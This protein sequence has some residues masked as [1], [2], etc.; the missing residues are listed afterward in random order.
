VSPVPDSEQFAT[1][2]EPDD[3]PAALAHRTDRFAIRNRTNTPVVFVDDDPLFSVAEDPEMARDNPMK[4]GVADIRHQNYAIEADDLDESERLIRELVEQF[5][6]DTEQRFHYALAGDDAQIGGNGLDDF[7]DAVRNFRT[8]YSDLSSQMGSVAQHESEFPDRHMRV[9]CVGMTYKEGF[10]LR[11]TVWLAETPDEQFHSHTALSLTS[12]EQHGPLTTMWLQD[13]L[14]HPALGS[15]SAVD[16]QFVR[17]QARLPLGSEPLTDTKEHRLIGYRGR[18]DTT[19][20][21]SCANPYYRS[22]DEEWGELFEHFREDRKLPDDALRQVLGID[23]L[24]LRPKG[25]SHGTDEDLYANGQ[26]QLTRFGTEQGGIALLSGK[27]MPIREAEYEARM[28]RRSDHTAPD[29]GVLRR[30]KP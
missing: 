13:R 20:Y 23:R 10:W 21:V 28:N 17:S 25:G 3:N 30:L 1:V 14:D 26:I 16:R 12:L 24:L 2:R 7:F 15:P 29:Q 5:D 11:F 27:T 22:D 18:D 19:E 6:A 4:T 9:P 8:I